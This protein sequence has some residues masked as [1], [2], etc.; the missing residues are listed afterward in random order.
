METKQIK[1]YSTMYENGMARRLFSILN[2]L[3]LLMSFPTLFMERR[4]NLEI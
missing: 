2:A 3:T 4:I 1:S